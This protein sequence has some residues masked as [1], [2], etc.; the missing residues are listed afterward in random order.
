MTEALIASLAKIR[1]LRVISRTSAMQYKACHVNDLLMTKLAVDVVIEKI[2]DALGRPG[3]GSCQLPVSM[4]R[5]TG[6]VVAGA[7]ERD[8]P[9][10]SCRCRVKS[11]GKSRVKSVCF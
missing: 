11:R 10:R 3:P 5:R 4:P 7:Y 6:P 1:A 8:L 9:G 2:S